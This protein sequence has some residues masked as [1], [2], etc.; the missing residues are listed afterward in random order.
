[1][2]KHTNPPSAGGPSRSASALRNDPLRLPS[3]VSGNFAQFSSHPSRAVLIVAVCRW[4][5]DRKGSTWSVPFLPRAIRSSTRLPCAVV[6]H[7]RSHEPAVL[8]RPRIAIPA[9]PLCLAASESSSNSLLGPPR[10][11]RTSA[12]VSH[13]RSASVDRR[14]PGS[15]E[16]LF[17][18]VCSTLPSLRKYLQHKGVDELPVP[19]QT[20]WH[21]RSQHP[22]LLC[23]SVSP[24]R[25]P[26]RS[27]SG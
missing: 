17:V 27:C 10:P 1:M 5:A 6:D 13:R 3:S 4:L 2:R 22:P 15:V 21:L 19:R 8:V 14:G 16:L 18:V 24:T 20:P 25:V 11:A 12:A 23:D 7:G 26:D 9:I